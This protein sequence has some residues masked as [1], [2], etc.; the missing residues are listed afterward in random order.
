MKGDGGRRVPLHTAG[1]AL[2][3]LGPLL[4]HHRIW[5]RWVRIGGGVVTEIGGRLTGEMRDGHWIQVASPAR[6]ESGGGRWPGRLREAGGAGE[7]PR[8]RGS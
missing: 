5:R 8:Q 2:S 1:C 6:W 3:S 4:P 7:E